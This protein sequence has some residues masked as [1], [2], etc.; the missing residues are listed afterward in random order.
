MTAVVVR[1][2]TSTYTTAARPSPM[3]SRTE[4]SVRGLAPITMSAPTAAAEA[5]T[6][7]AL[8]YAAFRGGWR[9]GSTPRAKPTAG[10][11]ITINHAGET[12]PTDRTSAASPQKNT[13]RSPPMRTE[14]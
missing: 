2:L 10:A 12:K 1:S 8:L 9:P 3:T 6:A 14:H 13:T 5:I 4:S 11:V 7:V